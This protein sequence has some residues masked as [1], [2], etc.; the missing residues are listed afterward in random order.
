MDL[1]CS[2][3]SLDIVPLISSLFIIIVY[4]VGDSYSEEAEKEFELYPGQ[5][6]NQIF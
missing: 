2:E 6:N 5:L 4:V 1:R 3:F